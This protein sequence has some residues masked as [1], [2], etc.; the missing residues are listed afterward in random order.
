L[1]SAAPF[2]ASRCHGSLSQEERRMQDDVRRLVGLEGF[3][4]KRVVEVGGRSM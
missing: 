4:V 1:R 3:E 2:E